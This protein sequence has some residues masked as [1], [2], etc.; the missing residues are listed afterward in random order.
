MNGKEDD[1]V[2]VDDNPASAAETEIVIDAPEESVDDKFSDRVCVE[3][4]YIIVKLLQPFQCRFRRN[5][6]E[7]V[8][9][10]NELRFRRA[11]GGDLRAIS[12]F[13]D[14]EERTFQ[15]FMRLAGIVQVQF[16]KIEY[17]DLA[18]CMEAV[19]HFLLTG[20][21]TGKS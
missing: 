11:N 15:L 16:D 10:I 21:G 12:S 14:E 18:F 1:I 19:E 9:S 6:S 4:D 2:I 8:E 17:N 7:T 20:P 3:D 5:G 13:R